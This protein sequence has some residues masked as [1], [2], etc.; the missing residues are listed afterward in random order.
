MQRA[1]F[2]PDRLVTFELLHPIGEVQAIAAFDQQDLK[3]MFVVKVG[4]FRAIHQNDMRTFVVVAVDFFDH[5]WL[6]FVFFREKLVGEFLATDGNQCR[7]ENRGQNSDFCH[8]PLQTN[9]WQASIDY[10][11]PKA[12]RHCTTT[13]S[14]ERTVAV[15]TETGYTTAGTLWYKTANRPKTPL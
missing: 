14:A 8:T 3:T 6:F 2:Y 12:M 13:M 10:G 15:P 7:N 1:F 4:L 5:Q 9:N 11:D